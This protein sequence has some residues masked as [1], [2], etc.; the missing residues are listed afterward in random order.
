[1]LDRVFVSLDERSK[2]WTD[3]ARLAERWPEAY[4]DCVEDRTYRQINIPRAVREEHIA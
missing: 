3:V 4:A 1:V 2:Q